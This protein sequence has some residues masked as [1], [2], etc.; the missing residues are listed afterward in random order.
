MQST[1]Q[2]LGV[3]R[4]QGESV[5]GRPRRLSIDFKLCNIKATPNSPKAFPQLNTDALQKLP[6]WRHIVVGGCRNR[7]FCYEVWELVNRS[8]LCKSLRVALRLPRQSIDS[9]RYGARASYEGPYRRWPP[10]NGGRHE[11]E[12]NPSSTLSTEGSGRLLVSGGSITT[13]WLALPHCFFQRRIDSAAPAG[14][15]NCI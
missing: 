11:C 5:P 2:L 13:V 12:G 9:R 4:V 1:A 8:G 3:A 15:P 7:K 6:P 14:F 10:R